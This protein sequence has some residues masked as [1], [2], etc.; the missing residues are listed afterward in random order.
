[1]LGNSS[2]SHYNDACKPVSACELLRIQNNGALVVARSAG[3]VLA[4]GAGTLLTIMAWFKFHGLVTD[5]L[6][7][8]SESRVS[9]P[10]VAAADGPSV[11]GKSRFPATAPT[12][13]AAGAPS[14]GV[15]K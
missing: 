11:T 8:D 15:D 5:R 14:S 1:M 6:G 4:R 3:R 10:S 9:V 2:A 7:A 12:K 13:P